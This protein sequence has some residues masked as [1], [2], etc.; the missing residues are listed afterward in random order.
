[1][2]RARK[3]NAI[4][5]DIRATMLHWPNMSGVGFCPSASVDELQAGYRTTL[6]IG[7][8]YNSTEYS[9]TRYAIG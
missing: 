3:G 9:V 1:M 4:I 5:Y 2:C 7:T 8:K 6:S